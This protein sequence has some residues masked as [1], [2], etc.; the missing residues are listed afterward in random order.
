MAFTFGFK[1]NKDTFCILYEITDLS[2]KG[3]SQFI[4]R[5]FCSELKNH[6]YINIMDDSGLVNL[7]RVK[8]SYHRRE[9][10]PVI[11]LLE[12]MQRNIEEIEFNHL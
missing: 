11:L 2:I 3:L 7:K 10:S 5:Q 8:L 12:K 4:F 6:R 1:L 9:Q